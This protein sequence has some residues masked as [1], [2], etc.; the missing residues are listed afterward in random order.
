MVVFL[1]G[2][3]FLGLPILMDVLAAGRMAMGTGSIVA[4]PFYNL[5]HDTHGN[6]S[7]GLATNGHADRASDRNVYGYTDEYIHVDIN[8][9]T[10]KDID[11]YGYF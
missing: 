9:Y 11:T 1:G 6:F 2:S 5:R 8:T 7:H 4:P 10:Y 3:S